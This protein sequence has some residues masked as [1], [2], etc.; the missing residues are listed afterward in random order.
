MRVSDQVSNSS[1]EDASEVFAEADQARAV[2]AAQVDPRPAQRE[3]DEARRLYDVASL[4]H[5]RSGLG[6]ID[7]APIAHK[8]L[9]VL[10]RMLVRVSDQEP[11]SDA[12][13]IAQVQAVNA[14]QSLVGYDVTE[15]LTIIAQARQQFFELGV[16]PSRADSRRYDRAFIRSAK[17]FGAAQDHIAELVPGSRPSPLRHWKIVA[18]AAFALGVGYVL[19]A[20]GKRP[21]PSPQL[22]AVVAAPAP[23]EAKPAASAGGGAGGGQL[24]TTFFRDP[25]LKEAAITRSDATLDFNWS[26]GEPP[27]L[28]QNDHFSVRWT[29]KLNVAAAGNY[30]FYLTSDDGSRLYIGDDL[31]IDNWGVHTLETKQGKVELVAGVYAFRVEFFDGTGDASLKLEWSSDTQPRRVITSQDLK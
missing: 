12:D 17:L 24:V 21:A 20:R 4:V 18:V 1:A 3:L 25:E 5:E 19:G 15:D 28:G 29:N 8:A 9:T 16:E 27:E 10:M 14:K 13:L 30:E 11:D 2:K 23:Q 26:G 31:V 6:S 7:S 22:P